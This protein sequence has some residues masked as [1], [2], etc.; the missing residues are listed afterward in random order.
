MITVI[1]HQFQEKYRNLHEKSY[2]MKESFQEALPSYGKLH[3]TAI[4]P[5]GSFVDGTPGRKENN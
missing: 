1:L 2:P 5:A 4:S 3:G